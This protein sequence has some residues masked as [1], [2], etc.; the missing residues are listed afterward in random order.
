M[1]AIFHNPM[2]RRDFVKGGL[3]TL[4][5]LVTLTGSSTLGARE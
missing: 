1:A 3:A 4:G 2:N 5:T